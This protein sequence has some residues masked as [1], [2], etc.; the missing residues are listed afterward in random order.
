MILVCVAVLV[1]VLGTQ[2][3]AGA[4]RLPGLLLPWSPEL[5]D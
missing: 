2:V 4:A 1:L 5:W 3:L